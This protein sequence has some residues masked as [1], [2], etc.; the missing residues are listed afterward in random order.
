MFSWA[1]YWLN[2]A[3]GPGTHNCRGYTRVIEPGKSLREDMHF[4]VEE[5]GEFDVRATVE[6]AEGT[7]LPNPGVPLR[8]DTTLAVA[9][10]E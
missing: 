10:S 5:P 9:A 4:V 2:T 1:E 8:V 3:L 7:T 6:M